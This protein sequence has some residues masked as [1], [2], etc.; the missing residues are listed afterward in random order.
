M[1]AQDYLPARAG[2]THKPTKALTSVAPPLNPLMV[3]L[4]CH[5]QVFLRAGQMAQLDKLRTDHLNAAATT[6]QKV[7]RGFIARRRFAAAKRAVLLLQVGLRG[8][9]G[10]EG[11]WQWRTKGGWQWRT[12]GGCWG[13]PGQDWYCEAQRSSAPPPRPMTCNFTP[14]RPLSGVTLHG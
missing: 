14:C 9:E 12:K 8:K 5:Q 11:G 6:L 7:A 3:I 2:T 4:P 13:D 10:I 1:E